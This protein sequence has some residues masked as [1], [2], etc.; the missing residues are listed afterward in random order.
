[1]VAE[2]ATGVTCA[3]YHCGQVH[4]LP[5][6][7]RLEDELDI[8]GGTAIELDGHELRSTVEALDD[9]APAVAAAALAPAELH[10]LLI[11]LQEEAS[12]LPRCALLV[13]TVVVLEVSLMVLDDHGLVIRKPDALLDRLDRLVGTRDEELPFGHE[14]KLTSC[15]VAHHHSI[16][17]VHTDGFLHITIHDLLVRTQEHQLAAI[18]AAP[19]DAD[20]AGGLVHDL[21]VLMDLEVDGGEHVAV[22]KLVVGPREDRLLA[23]VDCDLASDAVDQA[24]VLVRL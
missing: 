5:E 9:E 22:Q 24:H 2:V 23:A 21:H 16:V 15:L 1:M 17:V 10:N 12:R 11:R 14:P 19:L 6:E 20:L 7:S 13:A 18:L 4:D 3:L 8:V